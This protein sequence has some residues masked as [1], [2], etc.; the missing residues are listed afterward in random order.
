MGGEGVK[1]LEREFHL[2]GFGGP[3]SLEVN[4]IKPLKLGIREVGGVFKPEPS[5]VFKQ[6]AAGGVQGGLDPPNAVNRVAGM[7]NQMEFVKDER[8]V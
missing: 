2:V 8:G 4:A 3:E 5:G 1:V 7:S 6:R